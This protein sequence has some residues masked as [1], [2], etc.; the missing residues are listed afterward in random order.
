[1]PRAAGVRE[2]IGDM[3]M[4]PAP[5]M[6]DSGISDGP[7]DDA[8]PE[9]GGDAS[10]NASCGTKLVMHPF[11]PGMA[12]CFADYLG[13]SMLTPALPYFLADLGMPPHKVATWTGAVT[14]AQYA[15]LLLFTSDAADDLLGVDLVGCR[16]R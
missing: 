9:G 4:S 14:T 10:Q 8:V 1:M 7:G 6:V 11:L 15:G 5:E 16:I 3:A 13:M 2:E 12:G